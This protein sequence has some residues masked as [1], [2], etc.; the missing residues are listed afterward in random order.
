MNEVFT[1]SP[2]T[3]TRQLAKSGIDFAIVIANGDRPDVCQALL[4]DTESSYTHTKNR[5]AFGYVGLGVGAA[6]I[7]TGVVVPLTGPGKDE[8]AS[9][10]PE[11]LSRP[12]LAFTGGPGNW[13][14]VLSGAF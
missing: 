3:T 10:A 9:S 8:Y 4:D 5:D 1:S 2:T 11:K 14:A 6:A 12:R 13:G 7:A